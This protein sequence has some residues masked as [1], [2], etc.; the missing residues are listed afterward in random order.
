M[1]EKYWRDLLTDNVNEADAVVLGLP[2]DGAVSCGKGASEA[3]QVMRELSQY[4]P[5]VSYE[6]FIIN[7]KV[8]DYFDIEDFNNASAKINEVMKQKAFKL[9][10]GGDH[11]VSIKTQKAFIEHYQKQKFAIIHC[12]A[13]TDLCDVYDDSK[14]SHAC[15]NRRA[16]DNGMKD[17][18][19]AYLG[20]RSWE[21]QELE[22]YEKHPDIFVFPMH[23]INALGINKV[24]KLI[25]DKFKDYD[26][27]YL[28]VDI[29]CLDPSYAPGTGTPE[30]GGLTS[31]ELMTM[32]KVFI[33]NL[34]VVAMDVVEVAPPLDVNNITSWAALKLIYEVFNSLEKKN[35]ED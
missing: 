10:L 25:C 20:I 16:V 32:I 5:P 26:A 9:F 23:K 7:T 30:A 4:L 6:G 15:V 1:K 22:Y 12:D 29:D 2:Y 3:P 24:S 31:R 14:V 18:D 28:S 8:Y 19:I 21:I 13:H 33:E 11:S 34:K 17:E 27:I 35:E